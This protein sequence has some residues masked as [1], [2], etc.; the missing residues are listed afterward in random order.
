[1]EEMVFFRE[2]AAATSVPVTV[3]SS[4]LPPAGVRGQLPKDRGDL[5]KLRGCKTWGRRAI[6]RGKR[7]ERAGYGEMRPG[8]TP[9]DPQC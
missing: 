5:P 3:P 9:G 4:G 1:M 8:H 6:T 7:G 2:V